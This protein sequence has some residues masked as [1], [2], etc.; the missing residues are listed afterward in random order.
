MSNG[1]CLLWKGHSNSENFFKA[2][3]YPLWI[4]KVIVCLYNSEN[5][6]QI[7]Y[8]II[9]TTV[10][11]QKHFL[12]ASST[13]EDDYRCEKCENVELLLHSV[14]ICLANRQTIMT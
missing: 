10:S 1:N 5:E 2:H 6:L 3:H 9:Q 7:T 11:E 12:S 4:Y 8:H 13:P 14:K